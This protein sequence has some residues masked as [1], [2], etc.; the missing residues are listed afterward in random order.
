MPR[1]GPAAGMT[2]RSDRTPAGPP[3]FNG[4]GAGVKPFL[5]AAP[6]RARRRGSRPSWHRDGVSQPAAG[7]F[8]PGPGSESYH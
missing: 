1:S 8:R 6:G 3:G 4:C 5:S 2:V 7:R